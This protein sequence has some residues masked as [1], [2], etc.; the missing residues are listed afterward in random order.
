MKTAA[1]VAAGLGISVED[2]ALGIYKIA[3]KH[4]IDAIRLGSVSK[5]FDPRD[6]ALVAFGGAGAAFTAEIA[7]DLG[8]PAT[9][10]PHSPGVGAAAGLLGYVE[11]STG[12]LLLGEVFRFLGACNPRELPEIEEAVERMLAATQEALRG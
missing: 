3:C 10:V 5:G 12:P 11:R 7:R 8:I 6:F 4:M 2:A 9:I 1:P